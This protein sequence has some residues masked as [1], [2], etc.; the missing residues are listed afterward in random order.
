MLHIAVIIIGFLLLSRIIRGWLPVK[1]LTFITEQQF[2]DRIKSADVQI[3]DIRD[4]NNYEQEH[5]PNTI[6]IYLGRLPYLYK[7]E[8]DQDSEIVIISSSKSTIRK[9]ARILKKAG[10]NHLSGVLWIGINDSKSKEGQTKANISIV[11]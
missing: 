3:L 5:H 10:Y 4:P 8:L 2:F 9:A 7:K 11:S 1:G 6:N